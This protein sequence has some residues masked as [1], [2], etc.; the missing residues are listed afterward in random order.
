ML[1]ELIARQFELISRNLIF[2]HAI[3]LPRTKNTL[4]V[5]MHFLSRVRKI[6]AV[7]SAMSIHFNYLNNNEISPFFG[8]NEFYMFCCVIYITIN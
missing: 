8:K 3:F 1:F 6:L 4:I 7:D 5:L 2:V